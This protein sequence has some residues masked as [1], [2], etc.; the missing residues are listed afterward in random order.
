M[1]HFLEG[2]IATSGLAI[3]VGSLVRLWKRTR[4]PLVGAVVGVASLLPVGLSLPRNS[5]FGPTLDIVESWSLFTSCTAGVVAF[6]FFDWRDRMAPVP[7]ERYEGAFSRR[8]WLWILG[9]PLAAL[10]VLT[11]VVWVHNSVV[12]R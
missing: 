3:V 8:A 7:S 11:F 4:H 10:L 9:T 6:L 2:V 5:T 12:N 1:E